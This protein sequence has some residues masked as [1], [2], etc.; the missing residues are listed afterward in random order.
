MRKMLGGGYWGLKGTLFA[1][2]GGVYVAL[3]VFGVNIFPK[4]SITQGRMMTIKRQVLV[5]EK[6]Y[7]RLPDNLDELMNS[8]VENQVIPFDATDA[9]GQAIQYLPQTNDIVLLRSPGLQFYF[10]ADDTNY[11]SSNAQ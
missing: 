6:N 8:N 11:V 2:G 1:I 3:M 7:G 10:S 5:F 9:D 4:S